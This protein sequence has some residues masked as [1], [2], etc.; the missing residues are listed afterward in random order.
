MLPALAGAALIA[1]RAAEVIR[2]DISAE[3]MT[4]SADAEG[5]SYRRTV[6]IQGFEGEP[7]W[8]AMKV[9]YIVGAFS[10]APDDLLNVRLNGPLAPFALEAPAWQ[11]VVMPVRVS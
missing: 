1:K 10:E 5:G 4:V 6:P 3:G 9:P 11:A 2:L 8:V 7:M